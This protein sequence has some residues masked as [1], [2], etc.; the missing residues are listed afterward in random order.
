[1]YQTVRFRK[2]KLELVL[3]GWT[4]SLS[5]FIVET[6]RK[7]CLWARS[8]RLTRL[9]NTKR[10]RYT[11]W[12]ASTP[13]TKTECSIATGTPFKSNQACIE[14]LFREAVS[15]G[16]WNEGVITLICWTLYQALY[17]IIFM[18]KAEVCVNSRHELEKPE[19]SLPSALMGCL[20]IQPGPSCEDANLQCWTVVSLCYT[21]G[22]WCRYWL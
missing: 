10:A 20:S 3:L 15:D 2:A 9:Q 21:H 7:P 8:H 11:V 16:C 12:D 5:F 14:R 19:K 4:L 22:H 1:M 13:K 17:Q 18:A 6:I